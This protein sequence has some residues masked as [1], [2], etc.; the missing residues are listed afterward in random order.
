MAAPGIKSDRCQGVRMIKML[1]TLRHGHS[2]ILNPARELVT[3]IK[4]R[5]RMNINLSE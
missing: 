4:T 2:V 1:S 5:K 3:V